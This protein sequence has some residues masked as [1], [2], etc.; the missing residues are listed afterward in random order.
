MP[1]DRKVNLFYHLS[2]VHILLQGGF[3]FLIEIIIIA[4]EEHSYHR[5]NA[6]RTKNQTRMTFV[7]TP[8]AFV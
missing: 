7:R 4:Q 3:E 8:T 2:P 5:L 1:V 6:H